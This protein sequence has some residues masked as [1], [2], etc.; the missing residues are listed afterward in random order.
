MFVGHV[1]LTV[2]TASLP[3]HILAFHVDSVTNLA[4]AGMGVSRSENNWQESV[5]SS[6]TWVSGNGLVASTFLYLLSHFDRL[7]F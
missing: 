7:F 4:C 3:T 5:L 2:G 6:T 1:V